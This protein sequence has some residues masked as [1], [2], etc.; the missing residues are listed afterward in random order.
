MKYARILIGLCLLNI[1][2]AITAQAPIEQRVQQLKDEWY[3]KVQVL[4]ELGEKIIVKNDLIASLQEDIYLVLSEMGKK[5]VDD[6]VREEYKRSADKFFHKFFKAICDDVNMKDFF[7][8]ELILKRDDFFQG[9]KNYGGVLDKIKLN[10][11]Q[12]IVEGNVIKKLLDDYETCIQE[13]AE[14]DHQLVLLGSPRL[15]QN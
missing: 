4:A 2:Y 11:I 1:P 12:I 13:M 14:I 10:L 7:T 5:E 3:K 9:K 15:L 8:T 6:E